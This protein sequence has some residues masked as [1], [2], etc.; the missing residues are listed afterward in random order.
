[1]S[2]SWICV[3]ANLIVRLITDPHDKRVQPRWEQW[4]AEKR[5]F[6]APTLLLYEVT[7]AI[8]QYQKHGLFSA[9]AG[10]LA[11]T[12]AL[13]LPLQLYGDA[14]LHRQ[15]L[16]LARQYSLPATYDAHY[17]ALADRLGAEFWTRDERL[18]KAVQADLSWVNLLS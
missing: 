7:N 1:M 4:D 2:N 6:A 3:D 13:A 11:L 17:L 15:A 5:Q 8:Y 12:A 10:Q 9:E 16:N 14:E 18:F